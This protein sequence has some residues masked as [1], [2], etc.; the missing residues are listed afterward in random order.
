MSTVFKLFAALILL[1]VVGAGFSLL[2]LPDATLRALPGG[3]GERLVSIKR[4]TSEA[5]ANWY[6]DVSYAAKSL[7]W[8]LTSGD[9]FNTEANV[10]IE[11]PHDIRSSCVRPPSSQRRNRR[12]HLSRHQSVYRKYKRKPHLR[13][14]VCRHPPTWL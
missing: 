2:V 14:Q 4:N 3:Q 10:E 5:A 7:I 6:D 9:I 8:D 1:L 12:A 11:I 13:G